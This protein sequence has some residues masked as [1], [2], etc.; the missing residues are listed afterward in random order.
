MQAEHSRGNGFIVSPLTVPRD[1]TI[2]KKPTRTYDEVSKKIADL[3]NYCMSFFDTFAAEAAVSIKRLSS[4]LLSATVAVCC[5]MVFFRFFS[6]GTAVYYNGEKIASVSSEKEFYTALSAAK[7][8]AEENGTITL[9]LSFHTSPVISMRSN[10][11]AANTLRDRL[12]LC[13]PAFTSACTLYSG[14]MP[15]FSAENEETAQAVV[16]EHIEKYSMN[17]SAA[18]ESS[19]SYKTSVMPGDKV[20]DK[21]ECAELLEKSGSVAVVSVVSTTVN[22]EL[23]FETKTKQDANLYLGESITEI[24]GKT[25]TAEVDCET[26]YK[27]GTQQSSRILDENIIAKPVAQVVRVG[28]KQKEVLKTGLFYPVKGVLSSPFGSRWGK[29]HEGMDIAVDEGTPVMAAECGTVCYVNE[30]AGGYGKLIRIDHGHG[31]VTA[32]AHLSRIEV[33]QGQTVSANTQIALS[34]NTGR[35]TGPH[36][37]F[38]ILQNDTPIDPKEYLKE[39]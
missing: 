35:S 11:V 1:N 36:L 24:Q 18:I 14:G 30:N 8:F 32:Y 3:K 22:K 5:V 19:L 9:N 12:L 21:K 2:R 25:G 7:S 13:S 37:H 38:E 4:R 34:G 28:T 20:S 10:T 29:M 27:N 26:V 23:P 31:V 16:S 17:G 15:V 33:T 39:R 6:F